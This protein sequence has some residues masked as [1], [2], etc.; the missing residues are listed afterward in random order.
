MWIEIIFLVIFSIGIVGLITSRAVDTHIEIDS[1]AEQVWRVLTDFQAY[2]EWNPFIVAISG[3]VEAG[4][5]IFVTIKLPVGMKMDFKLLLQQLNTSR[6]MIWVGTTIA[7]NILDGRHY[8]VIESISD[9]KVKF[10]QGESYRGVLLYF[11]WPFIQWSVARSFS[12]MNDA[13]KQ[14]AEHDSLYEKRKAA[15]VV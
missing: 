1:S 6:E 9:N 15:G 10:S 11:C 8:F 14:R 5:K 2:A 3:P 7:R 12:E 4:N 13:L